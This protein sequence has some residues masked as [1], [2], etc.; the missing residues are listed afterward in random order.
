[1]SLLGFVKIKWVCVLLFA[2]RWCHHSS[3]VKFYSVQVKLCSHVSFYK[4]KHLWR[5]VEQNTWRK[6]LYLLESHQVMKQ[7]D[8]VKG[9]VWSQH[10]K[11]SVS[12]IMAMK[13]TETLFTE[14]ERPQIAEQE[15]T[16][17]CC[18]NQFQMG[19]PCGLTE[20]G[21]SHGV[22]FCSHTH[23]FNKS[24]SVL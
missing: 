15:F 19:E 14:W 8:T 22:C 3:H 12:V 13:S 5:K 17:L 18:E 20:N 6:T 21:T 16:F 9:W 24:P 23:C 11:W 4:S 10:L 7:H 1:M 2:W